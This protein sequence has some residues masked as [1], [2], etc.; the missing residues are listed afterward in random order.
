MKNTNKVS[1]IP[2]L[3]F[4][5]VAVITLVALFALSTTAC[6]GGGGGKS[7]NSATELKEYLDKQ[8]A[9]SPD[10][11]IKVAMKVNDM[12]I[13][14]VTT[15]LR[16]SD[17]YV[18]LNLSG[19]PLTK[20]PDAFRQL[21]TL[22][23][24]TIPDSV[25]SIG[26]LAFS[27]T[28][29]TSITIPAGVTSISNG[30]FS[31]CTSLTA[32]TVDGKNPAYAS[33]GGIVYNKAK[34]EI[35]AVPQGISGT[36][37]LPASVTSIGDSAFYDCTGLTGITIPAGVTSIGNQTFRNCTG[38]ASITIPASVTSI[39]TQ[40]FNGCDSLTAITIPAGVTTMGMSVFGDWTASQTINVQGHA[41]QAA[42]DAAWGGRWWRGAVFGDGSTKA[43]INYQGK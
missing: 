6:S 16:R 5:L 37:T 31:G 43:T 21:K 9:N 35:V 2:V 19:S 13:N 1:K 14:D 11:P 22:V 18:S 28:S 10:K 4:T 25:T 36:V 32:I 29:L 27:G 26:D 24:I 3:G 34:T 15:V 23:G 8:P 39:G 33:E 17:K 38:L 41:S 20:F 40:A 42:A 7:L 12:I 30:A